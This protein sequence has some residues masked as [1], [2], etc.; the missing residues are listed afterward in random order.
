MT[1][2][3]FDQT[4][5]RHHVG[6]F[7]VHNPLHPLYALIDEHLQERMQDIKKPLSPLAVFGFPWY[8]HL[9]HDHLVVMPDI[10]QDLPQE[11]TYG[12]VYIPMQLHWAHDLPGFFKK[13]YESLQDDGVLL[14]SCL[15]QGSLQELAHAL[16]QAD[17]R[18]F[19]GTSPRVS[20]FHHPKDIGHMLQ[21][22]GFRLITLDQD[23]LTLHYRDLN[24]I[25]QD[26]KS[27][28]GA[29]ALLNRSRRFVGREF[30]NTVYHT[31][32]HHFVRDGVWPLTLR[33]LYM[34]AWKPGP[35]Q[36]RSLNP[37]E[38]HVNLAEWFESK[39]M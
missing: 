20:L 37:G 8:T 11:N 32:Q 24:H 12:A 1:Q 33:I 23:R 30:W 10:Y 35:H 16:L 31:Y 36:P 17:I 22:A 28:A 38:A 39:N 7:L 2:D 13:C 25:L 4:L 14:A 9:Q 5:Y 29:N 3:L 15:V 6:R 27:A 18:E 26:I 34:T 19:G 21:N